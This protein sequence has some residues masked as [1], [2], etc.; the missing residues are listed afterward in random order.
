MMKTPANR[1]LFTRVV[2][3]LSMALV[4]AMGVAQALHSHPDGSATSHHACSVCLASHAGMSVETETI[5]PVMVASA[6]AVPAPQF[7]G[8]S[9][10]SV[11]QFIR[12]PPGF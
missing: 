7:A 2:C 6:L 9:R 3:I 11:T 12:P 8:I 5:A 10:P 4:C 1:S